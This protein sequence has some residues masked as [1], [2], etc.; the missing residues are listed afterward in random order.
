M[1]ENGGS[2]REGVAARGDVKIERARTAG[3]QE[4]QDQKVRYSVS[5]GL[6]RWMAQHGVSL[7]LSSYQSGFLYFIGRNPRGGINIHQ[8]VLPKPMG[9][10]M[11]GDELIMTGGAHV[12][13]FRNALESG[14]MVNGLFDVC[15]VPRVVH[16]TGGLDAHDVGV[17]ANGEV[18]F[19]NTRFNCLATV[20]GK[21]SF[22]EV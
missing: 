9:L 12:M 14:H 3:G 7:A 6:S 17:D 13:R 2:A 15:Y 16:V 10:Y 19:V 21:Y 4:G 22:E 18:I 5:L 1:S 8:T 20:S 11:H